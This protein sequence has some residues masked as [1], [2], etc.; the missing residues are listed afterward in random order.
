MGG[1]G[2]FATTIKLLKTNKDIE[3][4]LNKGKICFATLPFGTGNDGG[5]AFGWGN[6]PGS[7]LWM[8]DLESLMRDLIKA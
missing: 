5:Q 6:S 2:S 4:G 8:H 7:E 1:D 3:N